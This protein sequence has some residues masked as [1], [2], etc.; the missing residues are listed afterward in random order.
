MANEINIVLSETG[1]T[2]KAKL[3]AGNTQEGADINLTENS[4]RSGHYYGDAP[5]SVTNGTYVLI[6][7]T[8]GGVVKGSNEVQFID[9]VL[10]TGFTKVDEM[11]KVMGLNSSAPVTVTPTSLDAGTI[12]VDITGDGVTTTTETRA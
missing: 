1:L 9:N 11:H 4:G 3:W 5:A 7:E 8:N 12:H 2:L 6:I 10:Q